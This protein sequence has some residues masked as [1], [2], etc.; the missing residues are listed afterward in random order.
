MNTYD[1]PPA[2]DDNPPTPERAL[3]QD[4][5]AERAV[6]GPD[7]KAGQKFQHAVPA[8]RWF[9]AYP[10]AG[11]GFSFVGCTVAPGF[12]FADFVL[13]D[14]KKLLAQYPN[15]AAIINKLTNG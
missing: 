12:D 11:G 5:P 3:P 14:R 2:Y 9:G 10:E 6:L 4:I 8:G 15:C 13:A 1:G 7:L